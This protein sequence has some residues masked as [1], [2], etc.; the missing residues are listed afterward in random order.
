MK[1]GKP[2]N[3]LTDLSSKFYNLIPHN[4]GR[5]K[6]SNFIINTEK[7]LEA[8]M[9]LISNLIDIKAGLDIQNKKATPKKEEIL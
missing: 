6:M 3:S 2:S 9:E 4:F 5:Q 1:K 7:V 8:K